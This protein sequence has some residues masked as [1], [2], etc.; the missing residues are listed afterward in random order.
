ME[1][2]KSPEAR[3]RSVSDNK[4]MAKQRGNPNW[5]KPEPP[6]LVPPT[7]AF[8]TEV[9]RLRLSPEQYAGS[10]AL[11]DWV[12]KNKDQ[13]YV[14]PAVLEAFGFEASSEI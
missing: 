4:K 2:A 8:E 12:R 14:P 13:K 11:R 5:G 7:S 9:K 1:G 10:S 6:C 3:G